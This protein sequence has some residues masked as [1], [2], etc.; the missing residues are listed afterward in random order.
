MNDTVANDVTLPSLVHGLKDLH[1]ENKTTTLN[2]KDT[3]NNYELSDH[4]L[5]QETYST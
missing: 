1:F 5:T 3:K 2:M 4:P